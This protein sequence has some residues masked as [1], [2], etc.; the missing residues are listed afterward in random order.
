MKKWTSLLFVAIV[1]LFLSAGIANAA[2]TVQLKPK[3]IL[4]G[5]TLQPKVPP[6]IIDKYV[7]VPVR[8]VSENMGYTVGYDSTKKQVTVSDGAKDVQM[9]LN[10]ATAYVDGKAQTMGI[11]PQIKSNNVLIPLRFLGDSLDIQV[12][13]DNQ[14]KAAFV[15]S[16]GNTNTGN[17][18]VSDTKPPEGGMIG[19]LPDGSNSDD[20]VPPADGMI[21]NLP[22]KPTDPGPVLP[23]VP[24][25]VAGHIHEVRYEPDAVVLKYDGLVT[26]SVTKLDFPN[27]V[28]VDL[29]SADFTSDFLPALPADPALG[30]QGEMLVTS[31]AALTKIRYSLYADNPRTLRFVLDLNQPWDYTILNNTT[32]GELRID[33]KQ[34]EPDKSLYTV[35]L[36]AGHGGK[37]PGAKGISGRFEK[38][39]NLIIVRKVQ[40]LLA[41][42][43]RIKLVL[44]RSGDTY[45]TL[46]DRVNLANSIGADLFISVHANSYYAS[47]NGTETYYT[48]ANSLSFAKLMHSL[49]VQATGLKDNHVRQ[50]GFK[51]I[52]YTTM[53]AI[54]LEAGYLS[55]TVDEPR[56]WTAALQDR[57]AAA[58]AKGIKQQLK[59]S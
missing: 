52:K 8:I 58:I 30:K 29:P 13:W 50:A 33:L 45:P 34:P 41:N 35:V 59:L 46:D 21:G 42:D 37:D 54:L 56:L 2:T 44:T 15:Y 36:D 9:T 19:N 43:D 17:T 3:L 5:K 1:M 55:N 6:V 23:S 48:R 40:A 18:D 12:M 31:D 11:A 38:E 24:P 32:T 51:V 49:M 39:F 28:V 7:M 4:D 26:P 14:I 20:T 57:V 53:P 10:K 27:R 25:Q 47:T 22:D 16:S